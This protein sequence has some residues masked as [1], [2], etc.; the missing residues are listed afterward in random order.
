MY[1]FSLEFKTFDLDFSHIVYFV[2]GPFWFAR[3][4]KH[5]N[6]KNIY[7]YDLNIVLSFILF[8]CGEYYHI[9]IYNMQTKKVKKTD[10]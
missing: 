10:I 5:W 3:F 9:F 6:M 1:I 7:K 2:Q 4:N 8:L